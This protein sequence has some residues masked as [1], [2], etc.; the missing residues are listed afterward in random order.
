[1]GDTILDGDRDTS[2]ITADG[3]G[4][5]NKSG[6][7]DGDGDGGSGT[8]A[9][10]NDTASVDDVTGL[11]MGDSFNAAAAGGDHDD[12]ESSVRKY[13]SNPSALWS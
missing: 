8:A 12:V 6:D 11:V 5:A 7:L 10:R 2:I 1:M 9:S 3:D 4:G 13:L